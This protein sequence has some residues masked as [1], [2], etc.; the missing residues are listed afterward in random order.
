MCKQVNDRGRVYMSTTRLPHAEGE[1]VTL[2]PCVLSFRTHADQIAMAIDDIT[3]AAD[4]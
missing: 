4:C 2:R 1:V 3:A